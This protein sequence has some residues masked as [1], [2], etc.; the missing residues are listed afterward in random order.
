MNISYHLGRRLTALVISGGVGA[1]LFGG[2]TAQTQFSATSS[3]QATFKGGLVAASVTNGSFTC[4]GLV[5]PNNGVELGGT[6]TYGGQTC[7]ETVSFNNTGSVRESFDIT[8]GTVVGTA[9]AMAHL[10]QL[11]FTVG[12]QTFSYLQATQ[13]TNPFHLATIAPGASDSA[14]FTVSLAADSANDGS[15]NAWNGAG[16]TIPYTVTATP[17]AS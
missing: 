2:A 7:Q 16:V 17:S 8:I 13:G 9:S 1:A 10:E 4:S 14:T 3:Q 6:G 5:P 15:Q 11:K 12:G